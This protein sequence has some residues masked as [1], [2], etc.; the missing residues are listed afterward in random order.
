MKIR[1]RT[2]CNLNTCPYRTKMAESGCMWEYISSKNSI[3]IA[4]LALILNRNREDIIAIVKGA[5]TK[6]IKDVIIK[7][8]LTTPKIF[9][10]CAYCGKAFN[11]K[12][13]D[14][15]TYVCQA[16]CLKKIHYSHV[17]SFYKKPISHVLLILATYLNIGII[18]K[19][20]KISNKD[21]KNMYLKIFGDDSLLT[22][23]KDSKNKFR[24]RKEVLKFRSGLS[25]KT[26]SLNFNII[27]KRIE[28][29]EG[30]IKGGV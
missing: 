11:L 10:C 17:E 6:I 8:I 16:K 23:H 4:E 18:A 14:K 20:L 1:L 3:S 30:S 5:K 2:T 21:V 12:L 13:Q 29:L 28:E 19:L 9:K 15:E 22:K 27:E 26:K 7:R 24:K 25:K